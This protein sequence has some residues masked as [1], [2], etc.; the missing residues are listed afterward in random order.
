MAILA[1]GD[2]QAGA[3]LLLTTD[4]GRNTGVF[5]RVLGISGGYGW[6]MISGQVIDNQE[7]ISD[8]IARRRARDP[9]LWVVELDIPDAARFAAELT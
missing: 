9:D 2:E 6:S 1:R 3:I 7:E 8:L 5:E 4:R